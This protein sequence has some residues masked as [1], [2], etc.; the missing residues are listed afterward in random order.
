MNKDSDPEINP[1]KDELK[2]RIYFF[3]HIK[4]L[5]IGN[6]IKRKEGTIMEII[7]TI[8]L[9]RAYVGTHDSAK[10][11]NRFELS[12][13]QFNTFKKCLFDLGFSMSGDALCKVIEPDELTRMEVIIGIDKED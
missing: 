2:T 8:N 13:D 7:S 11:V 10:V 1:G 12:E 5:I 3:S 4:H 9:E 6:M